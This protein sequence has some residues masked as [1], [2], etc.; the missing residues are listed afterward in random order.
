MGE[1]S[2]LA[3]VGRSSPLGCWLLVLGVGRSLGV[4]GVV[5]SYLLGVGLG[6]SGWFGWGGLSETPHL[7]GSGFALALV[8]GVGHRGRGMRV[9]WVSG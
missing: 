6:V 9:R 8:G 1:T 7:S 3:C 2:R 5:G 4:S